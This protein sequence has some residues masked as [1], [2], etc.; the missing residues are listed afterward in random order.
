MLWDLSGNE[1][2][3]VSL[4]GEEEERRSTTP[5]TTWFLCAA[6]EPPE[7]AWFCRKSPGVRLNLGEFSGM[8]F[9]P[10]RKPPANVFLG[11]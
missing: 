4:E 9:H 7:P 11:V 1:K 2:L 5:A 10:S 3:K 6:A 8:T